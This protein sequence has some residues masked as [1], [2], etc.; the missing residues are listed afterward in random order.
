VRDRHDPKRIRYGCFL[1]DLTGLATA[2]PTPAPRGGY[3]R[4]PA[5]RYKAGGGH[6]SEAKK[7]HPARSYRHFAAALGRDDGGLRVS[8]RLSPSEDA[9]EGGESSFR[10]S[11]G[12]ARPAGESNFRIIAFPHFRQRWHSK[13]GRRAAMRESYIWWVLLSV[14]LRTRV[15][16]S[17][18]CGVSTSS[19]ERGDFP[20]FRQSRAPAAPESPP[21]GK[22]ENNGRDSPSSRAALLHHV[23]GAPWSERRCWENR[24]SALS[25]FRQS[26]ADCSCRPPPQRK[27]LGRCRGNPR[28]R[29]HGSRFATS[30][31]SVGLRGRHLPS[32]DAGEKLKRVEFP[33]YRISAF[34]TERALRPAQGRGKRVA[35]CAWQGP[36]GWRQLRSLPADIFLAC[37]D[38]RSRHGNGAPPAMSRASS[39]GHSTRRAVGSLFLSTE[40]EK[41]RWHKERRSF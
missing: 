16:G 23:R 31:P 41:C 33:H 9:G 37:A 17:E 27:E 38:D 11:A 20:I 3:I 19:R 29:G 15:R 36:A 8:D 35:E 18:V 28:R 39:C 1:P 25:H 4:S 30:D 10:I 7:P 6:F 5:A 34:P 12:A 32:E 21:P 22:R 2:P 14:N 24:I 40:I 26:R 13:G